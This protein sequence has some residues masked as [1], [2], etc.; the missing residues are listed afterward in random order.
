MAPGKQGPSGATRAAGVGNDSSPPRRPAGPEVA[1]R[2]S[3]VFPLPTSGSPSSLGFHH[4]DSAAGV[5][6]TDGY[7]EGDVARVVVQVAPKDQL[8]LT[9]EELEKEVGPR[10]LYPQNPRAPRNVA[11]FSFKERQYKKNDQIDHSVIHLAITGTLLPKES[12]EAVDQDEIRKNK[13]EE[14]RRQ[15]AMDSVDLDTDADV[16]PDPSGA[17]TRPSRNQFDFADRGS[18]TFATILRERGI[19]TRP[20]ATIRFSDTVNQWVIYDHYVADMES[21]K[22]EELKKP[23]TK[24]KSLR[25][26]LLENPMYSDTMKKSARLAERIV[27][28][29]A[30]HEVYTDFKS[31]EDEADTF[32]PDKGTLL[33]LWRFAAQTS[34]KQEVTAIK[35][36]PRYPD[37]FAVGYGS[38]EFLNQGG[39]TIRCY[40][41]KNTK[42]PEYTFVTDS[43][44]TCL[45][46]HQLY[47]ALLAVGLYD[48]SVRVFDLRSRSQN[49]IYT[50]TI[51]SR[52]HTDPVWEVR[53]SIDGSHGTPKFFSVSADGRVSSWSFMK[54]R[55][56]A[57][58]VDCRFFPTQPHL[59]LSEK[60][61]EH[62]HLNASTRGIYFC[63]CAPCAGVFTIDS[64]IAGRGRCNVS[65]WRR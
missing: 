37:L 43:G 32:R 5:D 61:D 2:R 14:L 58:E 50:S 30:E 53:W 22:N 6:G 28:Q 42:H 41:L 55:L 46:W 59:T 16:V 3:T 62:E 35:W 12:Q 33:P 34:R 20:R 27:N 13:E 39:G 25:T 1:R 63:M 47:P 51:E 36:N 57:E 49:P 24:D 65:G 15:K 45:D 17:H 21:E 19:S 4:G 23:V 7:D 11:L 56:E 18:Q 10:L 52:Q 54:N 44:I 38:Y 48:G 26:K 64:G 8:S 9:Q 31:Y 29:N 40:T 60:R